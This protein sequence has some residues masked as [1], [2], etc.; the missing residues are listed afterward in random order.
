M[1]QICPIHRFSYSGNKCPFCEQERLE[2]LAKKFVVIDHLN[3]IGNYEPKTKN[4]IEITEQQ[5]KKLADKFNVKK[6]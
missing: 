5:L 4:D 2:I 3:I 1:K 6:R